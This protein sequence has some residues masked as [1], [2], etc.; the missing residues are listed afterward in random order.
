MS[1]RTRCLIVD[2]EPLALEVMENHLN[3]FDGL[4]IAAKCSSAVEAFEIVNTQKIDLIF[5]D[6]QMPQISG[7]D[8]LRAIKNPPGVILTTAYREYALESYELEVVD[9]LLKPISFERLMMAINKFYKQNEGKTGPSPVNNRSRED[10]FIYLK[11]DK[12]NVKLPYDEILYIE[13]MKDYVTVFTA[14]SKYISKTTMTDLEDKLPEN[15]FIR[16]HRSF[17]VS[18]QKITAF[19]SYSVEIGRKELT[20]GRS[21]KEEVMSRLNFS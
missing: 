14:E 12:K 4:E 17:I 3:K 18:K 13:C 19:T 8:F 6:I 9:Y 2:D 20:I 1:R 21:Y 7:L 16:I 15:N 11:V 5:L 10:D